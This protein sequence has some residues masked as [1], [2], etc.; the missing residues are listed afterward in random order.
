MFETRARV[1]C[2]IT[3]MLVFSSQWFLRTASKVIVHTR[4]QK[5]ALEKIDLIIVLTNA[6]RKTKCGK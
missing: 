1:V 3:G 4:L 5:G 2:G 6:L